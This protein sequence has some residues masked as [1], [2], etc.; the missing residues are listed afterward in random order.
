MAQFEKVLL[1]ATPNVYFGGKCVS[2]G[3]TDADGNTKSVGVVQPAELTFNTEAA[4]VME[5]TA[6]SCSYKLASSD[7]W[8]T[9][10]VG[11]SF[12]VAANSSFDIRVVDEPFGYICSYA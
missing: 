3:F 6:G 7:E 10:K 4:E 9:C 12:Q 11:E 2:F 1:Q 5:C 8:K